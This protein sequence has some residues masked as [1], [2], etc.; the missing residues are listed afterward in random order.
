[1]TPFAADLVADNAAAVA[2]FMRENF[3]V[4]HGLRILPKWDSRHMYDGSQL[5]M[6]M[7]I[8]ENFHREM[9]KME[10]D[11]ESLSA[12][13]ANIEWFWN[14]LCIPEALTCEYENHGITVDNPGRKQ[15][16]CAKA[17]LSMFYHV[18]AGVN[19]ALDGLSFS[20]S[21]GGEISIRNL[22]CRGRTIDIA[23]TG[24]GWKIGSL[25]LN[26]RSVPAPFKIPFSALGAR[27]NIK[28]E[29]EA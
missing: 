21:D 16:F 18:A 26:G 28:L 14:Q 2:K 25:S 7:P 13:F 1:M 22:S 5:G 19:I 12:M 4:R 9:M 20:P 23:T 3:P 29:R 15:L 17:W 10:C 24:H 11:S 6:Y 27:N 8:I